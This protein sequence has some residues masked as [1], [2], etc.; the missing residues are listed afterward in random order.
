MTRGIFASAVLLLAAKCTP[1][2]SDSGASDSGASDSGAGD[3]E[4]SDGGA[5]GSSNKAD[6]GPAALVREG[7]NTASNTLS[8]T[9]TLPNAPADGHALILVVGSNGNYPTGVSGGGAASWVNAVQSGLHVASATPD[10]TIRWGAKQ[11]TA[12][13]LLTEWAGLSALDSPGGTNQGSSATPSVPPFAAQPGQLLFAAAGTQASTST[14]TN[15]F[16]AIAT[17][18]SSGSVILVGAYL[19]VDTASS[20][21]TSWTMSPANGWDTMLVALH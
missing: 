17:P 21:G 20:H 8:L 15:G 16:T 1:F 6:A 9:V 19:R 7:A 18:A 3:S 13:A 14:P 2:D 11:T 12:A 4:A 10:V 5:D